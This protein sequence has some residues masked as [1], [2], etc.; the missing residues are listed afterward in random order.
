[1]LTLEHGVLVPGDG[2]HGLGVEGG[3]YEEEYPALPVELGDG[4]AGGLVVLRELNVCR[5]SVCT[6][7]KDRTEELLPLNSGQP[8]Y[9]CVSVWWVGGRLCV[10]VC[11]W[12]VGGDV[13]MCGG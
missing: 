6:D 8:R 7:V 9:V 12:W 2:P 1:M 5:G 4:Q 13:C 10:C 3:Q 11:V